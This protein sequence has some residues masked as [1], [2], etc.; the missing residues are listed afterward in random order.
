MN[1]LVSPDVDLRGMPF[2]P[3]DVSRLRDSELAILATGD[4]F[5]AAVLLWCAAWNQLPAASLPNNDQ[6]L[7]AYAG[8]GR[9]VRGWLAVKAGAMRGFLLCT[10]G[11]WYHPVVAEKASEAWAERQEYR[12]GKNNEAERKRRE[13]EWRSLAFTALRGTGNTPP[14]NIKTADL[15]KLLERQG[16]QVSLV[17]GQDRGGGDGDDD[18]GGCDPGEPVTPPV[19]QPVTVTGHGRV[20]AKT[21]TG[22][23]IHTPDRSQQAPE[24]SERATLAGRAC[25]LMRQAGCHTTNPSHPDLIAALEEGV[26]PEALADTVGEGLARAPPVAKPFAWAITAARAR[27][28]EG[29]KPVNTST[30][31]NHGTRRLAPS[32][33]VEHYIQAREQAGGAA[34]AARAV[35]ELHGPALAAHVADLRPQVDQRLHSESGGPCGDNVVEGTFRVVR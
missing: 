11:R 34:D 18:A 14:W 6:A 4:E 20:T 13:R 31:S 29:P 27:H 28:A 30:G 8:F 1:P 12:A 3:L 32:D 15:R 22:T 2:M 19:T 7:A 25:V 10:D 26:T 21:G 9:D 33:E 5:R 35:S 24:I 16:L 17:N 23:G